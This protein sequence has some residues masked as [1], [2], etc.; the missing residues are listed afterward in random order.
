ME[1]CTIGIDLGKTAFH[2]VSVNARSRI[3][4]DPVTPKV[5]V[6][7]SVQRASPSQAARLHSSITLLNTRGIAT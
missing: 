4:N 1:I 6:R 2:L 7:L 3:A 5:K